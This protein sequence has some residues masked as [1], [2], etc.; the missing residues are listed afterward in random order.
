LLKIKV[1]FIRYKRLI[2]KINGLLDLKN[3]EAI[4]Q[5]RLYGS[6]MK[7]FIASKIQNKRKLENN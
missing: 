6:K 5:L 4:F 7:Q 1:L 2:S 3:L